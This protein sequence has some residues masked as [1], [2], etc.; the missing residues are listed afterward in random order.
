MALRGAAQLACPSLSTAGRRAES[1]E[2]RG[3]R[4]EGAREKKCSSTLAARNAVHRGRREASGWCSAACMPEPLPSSS[5]CAQ[6][7][8]LP[9]AR[10]ATTTRLLQDC[11]A[12]TPPPLCKRSAVTRRAASAR[13]CPYRWPARTYG[14]SQPST[15]HG[16][17]A[18]APRPHL[19]LT[20]GALRPQHTCKSLARQPAVTP[21]ARALTAAPPTQLRPGP[22]PRL[23]RSF[24]EAVLSQYA[25]FR[26]PRTR[27][28]FSWQHNWQPKAYLATAAPVQ[29]STSRVRGAG[30]AASSVVAGVGRARQPQHCAVHA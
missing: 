23:G 5:Q 3:N 6:C 22:P 12:V 8:A 24:R 20:A 16:P 26:P 2:R 13:A 28:R 18:Q 9:S 14:R 19:P 30:A 7:R 10:S 17:A 25:A 15:R 11:T 4:A 1:E 29:C 27:L 21:P